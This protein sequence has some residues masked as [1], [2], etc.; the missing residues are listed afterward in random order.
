M[1]KL[2]KWIRPSFEDNTGKASYRR[3]TAFVFVCLICYM[4]IWD[5]V[6]TEL[7]FK[8]LLALLITLMLLIGVVTAQN[9][10]TFFNKPTTQDNDN[11]ED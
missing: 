11:K 2:I 8:V 9:L 4:I 7:Q 5:K 3:M 6:K 1:Y 10:L